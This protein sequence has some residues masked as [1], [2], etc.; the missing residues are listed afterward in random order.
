MWYVLTFTPFGQR[1]LFVG[2]SREV[3]RLSGFKVG[4]TRFRGFVIAGFIAVH[5]AMAVLVPRTLR[6]MIRGR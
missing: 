4:A 6:A 2:Q 5:A 3:A 1:A